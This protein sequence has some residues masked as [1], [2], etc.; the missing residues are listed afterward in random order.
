MLGIKIYR[1]DKSIEKIESEGSGSY[2]YSNFPKLYIKNK[3]VK[4][5]NLDKLMLPALIGLNNIAFKYG[6][7]GFIITSGNDA[8][9]PGSNGTN[10]LHFKNRA[11]DISFR[12]A[13]T[14]KPIPGIRLSSSPMKKEL[15]KALNPNLLFTD[16]D[17][18]MEKDHIH[19]EYDPKGGLVK[20]SKK[21]PVESNYQ[22]EE[23]PI[24]FIHTNVKIKTI[25]SL[26]ASSPIFSR[27]KD[28]KQ[29]L[30]DYKGKTNISNQERIE[31]LYEEGDQPGTLKLNTI[32]YL[33]PEMV[34]KDF[35]FKGKND[36]VID[37]SNFPMFFSKAR[38]Q[39]EQSEGYTPAF[40][41]STN[42]EFPVEYINH[43]VSVW[44]YSKG[45]GQIIDITNLCNSVMTNSDINASTFSLT[46]SI[47]E[48]NEQDVIINSFQN[49]ISFI[50]KHLSE[51]D[52]IWIRFETLDSETDRGPRNEIAFSEIA[53]KV[54]DFMGFINTV[55]PEVSLGKISG[56]VSV[57]GQCFS[58]LF[59]NDEAL[60]FPISTVKDSMTGNL[61]IGSFENDNLLKRLFSDGKY[62]SLFSKQYRTIQDSMLFYM[63]Q[64]SNTGMVPKEV[65]DLIFQSYK[66]RR[67]EVYKVKGD[68]VQESLVDGVYQII[69]I[70][71]DD[72]VKDRTIVDASITSPS[73]SI[74]SLFNKVCQYPL[75]ELLTDTYGD[76]YNIIVRKPPFD[77]SSIVSFLN[78][79]NPIYILDENDVSHE[80]LSFETN[81]STWF[82]IE[83]TGVFLGDSNHVSLTYIP[84]VP[85]PE[86]IE[87][88]G[89][90][91]KMITSNYTRSNSYGTTEE[92]KQVVLDLLYVIECDIYLPFSRQGTITLA[93]GDRRIKKGT[94]I[95][96][97]DE[98][99]YI[100]SVSNSV[101]ISD[102]TVSRSTVL[103][104]SR[105]IKEAYV[106]GKTVDGVKISYFDLLNFENLK[107][108]MEDF[109]T[110]DKNRG[111]VINR[112]VLID[113]DIF[114][115]FIS[116]KQLDD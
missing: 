48:T 15:Q 83:N 67:K 100:N 37:V 20:S 101:S 52:I 60:F 6:M 19:I 94:W 93:K 72:A 84:I 25:D 68:T 56:S 109:L 76:T 87:Y 62:Y 32:L 114:N 28:D 42:N 63:N 59:T 49:N 69:N 46:C 11:I 7:K 91:K 4:I 95:R 29:R 98:I 3:S 26:L 41:Y 110:N 55:V 51:N 17:I 102:K 115:Y 81:F 5:D 64:L 54:Y 92:K 73:G 27:Y 78:Q 40:L 71:F 90:K 39:I 31:S 88:W 89:S 8:A 38:E 35:A 111:S 65:N 107:Q 33:E 85:I 50:Q 116:K 74:M 23:S 12:E 24:K 30:L 66:D 112:N 80:S 79:D 113:K 43:L 97:K 10:S 105:G 104:V 36:T 2:Y 106:E 77:K 108:T 70:L 75:V 21:E 1:K 44:V 82:Q 22:F 45:L 34:D 57:S 18:V 86:Y 53:G 47:I 96:Y 9:H 58:K 14:N 13:I 16:F 61:I 99:F 103:N